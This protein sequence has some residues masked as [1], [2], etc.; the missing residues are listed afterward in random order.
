MFFSKVVQVQKLKEFTYIY[1]GHEQFSLSYEF[2]ISIW[3]HNY[4]EASLN[5]RLIYSKLYLI[6]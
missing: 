5:I 1:S 6:I 2:I 4:A 3:K